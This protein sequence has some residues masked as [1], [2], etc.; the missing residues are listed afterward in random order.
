[1]HLCIDTSSQASGITLVDKTKSYGYVPL[2]YNGFSEGIMAAIDQLVQK[3]DI[4][5]SGLKGIFV[6][7]GPGSFT[8]LRVGITVAN[9]FAHQLNIPIIGIR[10][11]EFYKNRTD[12]KDF[13]YLQT[14]NRSEFYVV[15]FGK[16]ENVFNEKIVEINKLLAGAI[17]ESSLQEIGEFKH[18]HAE[19]LSEQFKKIENIKSVEDTWLSIIQNIKLESGKKYDLIQPYYG[20]DPSIT[21]AKKRISI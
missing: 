18:D 16:C 13:F 14:M 4:Q 10:M 3:A 8:G 1:L 12:E 20:K 5:L 19:K 11:E 6:L 2:E 7:Q 17:G 21:K 9:Q 15:G